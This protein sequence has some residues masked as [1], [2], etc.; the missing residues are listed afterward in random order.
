[1]NSVLRFLCVLPPLFVLAGPSWSQSLDDLAKVCRAEAFRIL[2]GGRQLSD[3][4]VRMTSEC[5]TRRKGAVYSPAGFSRSQFGAGGKTAIA[6]RPLK[7]G[8]WYSI[9]PDCSSL[10][11]TEVRIASGPQRGT[12]AVKQSSDFPRYPSTNSR[13][14]CNG[15]RVTSTQLW[16]TSPRGVVGQDHVSA[17]I[18]FPSGATRN[19]SFTINVVP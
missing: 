19:P 6:G 1:M 18:V 3:T 17:V 12:L 10:G 4:I 7:L 5:M 16:Y 11:R 8:H 13:S 14:A 2:G 9:N 15:R